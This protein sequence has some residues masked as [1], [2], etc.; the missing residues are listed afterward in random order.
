ME[1]GIIRWYKYVVDDSLSIIYQIQ[2]I[3]ALI[4]Q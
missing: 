4:K 3:G 2:A 1:H